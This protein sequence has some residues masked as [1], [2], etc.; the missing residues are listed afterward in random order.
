[1]TVAISREAACGNV[2]PA[3]FTFRVSTLRID[4][5]GQPVADHRQRVAHLSVPPCSKRTVLRIPARAPFRLDA[6][7]TGLFKAG[8]GRELSAFVGYTFTP[9]NR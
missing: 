2:P 9:T 3:R 4:D 5:D 7:A 6:T 8:D 1:V